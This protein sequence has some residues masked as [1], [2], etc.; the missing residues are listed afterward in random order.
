VP[1]PARQASG[2]DEEGDSMHSPFTSRGFRGAGPLALLFW[3]AFAATS[4]QAVAETEPADAPE[5]EG[6]AAEAAPPI[7]VEQGDVAP[8]AD[9]HVLRSVFTSGI[10]NR[11][12]VDEVRVLENDATRI[13]YFTELTGLSGQTLVHRW[14]HDGQVMAEV[15]FEVG[16]ARWRV[17]SSKRL[18]PS[19]LGEWRVSVV[20]S[21]GRVLASNEFEYIRAVAKS[22]EA[23]PEPDTAR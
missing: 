14:E 5:M 11:E 4:A 2:F 7:A 10:S 21:T 17:Y 23:A 9:H 13:F 15:P 19:W 12:P 8:S 20:D 22:D 1:T 3:L 6:E 18:D 16:A